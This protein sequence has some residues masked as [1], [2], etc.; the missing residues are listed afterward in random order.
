MEKVFVIPER[1]L[2]DSK[3]INVRRIKY[4]QNAELHSHEFYEVEMILSGSG[5]QVING[6]TYKFKRG[7]VC[8]MTPADFHEYTCNGE[9]EVFGIYFSEKLL[10]KSV[11]EKIFSKNYLKF[12]NLTEDKT[13]DVRRLMENIGSAMQ[14]DDYSKDS[15]IKM[16]IECLFVT[17]SGDIKGKEELEEKTPL[18]IAKRY[19]ELHFRENPSLEDV[20][21]VIGKS[22]VYFSKY[23]Y[24]N[25]GVYYTDYLNRQKVN[26]AKFLLAE[27]NMTATE[28]CYEAGFSSF[29]NFLRVFKE[30]EGNTPTK[31][32]EN[33]EKKP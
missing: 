5:E 26:C 11:L 3:S 23:F 28:I 31:Y 8:M 13:E 25:E 18:R 15:L 29:S 27:S 22:P 14:Y 6:E 9:V 16:L 12:I 2:G 17:V 19:I 33:I 7:S 32:R 30:Y 21:K 24:S 10:P 4:R 1:F 20:A